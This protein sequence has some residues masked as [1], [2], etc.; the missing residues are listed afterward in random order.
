MS[1]SIG[2]MEGRV[3]LYSLSH[4]LSR[5]S[6]LRMSSISMGSSLNMASMVRS[7]RTDRILTFFFGGGGGGGG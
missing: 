4:D 7:S 5:S 3:P 1:Y 6:K 2:A